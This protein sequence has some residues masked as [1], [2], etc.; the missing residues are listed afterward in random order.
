MMVEAKCAMS[1]AVRRW[2]AERQSLRNRSGRGCMCFV[3]AAFCSGMEAGAAEA[4]ALC[5]GS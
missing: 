2:A 5:S 1:Q 4:D 3:V